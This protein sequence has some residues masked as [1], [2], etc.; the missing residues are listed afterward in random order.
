[1]LG[2]IGHPD[3]FAG[4]QD[5]AATAGSSQMRSSAPQPETGFVVTTTGVTSVSGH[6]KIKAKL[7]ELIAAIV[8]LDGLSEMPAW[9]IHDLRRTAA[10]GMAK[11]G[12][13]PHVIEAVLNHRSS[14]RAGLV[15]VYQHYDHRPERRAAL[16]KWAGHVTTLSQGAGGDVRQRAAATP[17]RRLRAKS[18]PDLVA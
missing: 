8:A 1:M 14:V 15:A 7:N 6:G 13:N 2:D 12:F 18:R 5:E 11:L 16:T 3:G 4:G 17:K 9:R 10:T